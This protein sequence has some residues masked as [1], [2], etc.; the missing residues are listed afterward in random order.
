MPSI[1]VSNGVHPHDVFLEVFAQCCNFT[2]I[3]QGLLLVMQ[4]V[5]LASRGTPTMSAIEPIAPRSRQ[6]GK[7]CKRPRLNIPR[8]A[9]VTDCWLLTI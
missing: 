6:M 9:E 8:P 2:A 3:R 4:L 5:R 7:F 1:S